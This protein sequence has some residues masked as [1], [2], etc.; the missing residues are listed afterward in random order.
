[1]R[2]LSLSLLALMMVCMANAQQKD[3]EKKPATIAIHFGHQDFI[4]PQR[5]RTSSLQ[6]VMGNKRWAK[7]KDQAPALGISYMKGLNNYF[8]ISA[9]YYLSSVDYPFADATPRLGTD[10]LLHEADVSVHMKLLTDR[11]FLVPYLSA[12]LG[13]SAYK[14]S[15]FDAFMPFGAGL[16]LK[17]SKNSSLFSNFQY[18]VPITERGNYHFLTTFGAA[19]TFNN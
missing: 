17:L 19:Y 6:N 5:I 8:D 13:A 11:H 3:N 16:Q 9:N 15:R 18:R 10:Y 12:G 2:K 14:S 4:T 7:L 1:M